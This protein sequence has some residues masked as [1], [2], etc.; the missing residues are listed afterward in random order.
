MYIESKFYNFL[1]LL[2]LISGIFLFFDTIKTKKINASTRTEARYEII[3]NRELKPAP[4]K[5]DIVKAIEIVEKATFTEL[6][7]NNGVN[8]GTAFEIYQASK[9]IY[10]LSQIR[11]GYFVRLIYTPDN[12][13]KELKY[14]INTEEEL[15][16]KNK[17]YIPEEE[18]ASS[19]P[20]EDIEGDWIAELN[21]I[22]YEIKIKTA[23][24]VVETS[25]YEAAIDN[26]I[27]I[28]AIIELANTFQWTIDFALDPRVGDTFKF[29]FEERYLNG[30]YMM[31]GMVLA[32][33]YVNDGERYEIYYFEETEK[34]IG[35]FDGEGNSVQKMFLRAPVSFKYISSGFT[36]GRRYVEA[37]NVFTGH[38]A[39]DYAAISGTPIRSVGDGRV[40]Y[41][42]WSTVG[43][44]YLTKIRHNGTYTTNYGHQS[45]ILVRVGQRIKQGQVIGKVG[46]TGF[47]T[48]PHLHYEMVK[49]G[50]KI[51]PM[52]EIL[53]PG[54]KIKE[55]N[56]ERFFEEIKKYQ[57]ELL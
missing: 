4:I 57:E 42:G 46:S 31:P 37:F 28:R 12:E 56:K 30:N 14:K 26:D 50:V 29:I 7:K 15:S 44:G 34:N 20:K 3:K 21:S 33:V 18:I 38:R 23:G 39:I 19:S 25:M 6:L 53:P 55:E 35:Y 8:G 36:T 47:S 52:N 9:E 40:I 24:G 1:L 41:A 10:D 49:N 16:V 45:R 22:D 11:L 43:Y 27:D 17:L 48:G 13:F 2:I 54:Q 51:N 32:G 5:E